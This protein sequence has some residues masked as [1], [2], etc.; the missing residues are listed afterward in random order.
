[1][2]KRKF[3]R[4]TIGWIKEKFLTRLDFILEWKACGGDCAKPV[5]INTND[6]PYELRFIGRELEI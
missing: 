6:L 1:M 2:R 3:G 5:V 4:R